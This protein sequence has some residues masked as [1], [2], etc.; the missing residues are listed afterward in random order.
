MA[1]R[2][3]SET[4]RGWS[5]G[6]VGRVA[7]TSRNVRATLVGIVIVV[8]VLVALTVA[9]G[10]RV[11]E[12]APLDVVSSRDPLQ[13]LPIRNAG[14][15]GVVHPAHTYDAVL[16][17]SR[18]SS[19][20]VGV[21][22]DRIRR[23]ADRYDAVI[24]NEGGDEMFREPIAPGYFEDGRFMLRL[25]TRRF[26]AGVYWLEIEAAGQGEESRVVAASWFEVVRG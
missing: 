4:A 5:P 22:L 26:P 6:I 9:R 24:R 1:T 20:V 15:D 23:E 19:L 11:A 25:F 17:L 10:R 16:D 21:D 18:I 2:H 13:E 12:W 7:G 3:F 8:G 14:R